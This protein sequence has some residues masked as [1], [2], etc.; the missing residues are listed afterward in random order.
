[1]FVTIDEN[2]DILLEELYK[3]YKTGSNKCNN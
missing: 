2:D 1:M 3:E